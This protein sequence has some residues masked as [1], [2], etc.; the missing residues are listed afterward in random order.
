MLLQENAALREQLAAPQ[1]T[2]GLT[3]SRSAEANVSDIPPC[4]DH[5]ADL[6]ELQETELLRSEVKRL[7]AE[8][9]EARNSTRAYQAEAA[10]SRTRCQQLE[11]QL[12]KAAAHT[13]QVLVKMRV[14]L[15]AAASPGPAGG[16]SLTQVSFQS[17]HGCMGGAH[18]LW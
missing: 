18:H 10:T 13:G 1:P 5:L 6:P 16:Q 12:A 4:M 17:S 7:R 9:D 11:P 3:S 14:E 2:T 15:A 8:L